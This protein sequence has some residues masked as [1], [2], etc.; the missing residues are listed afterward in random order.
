LPPPNSQLRIV[1]DSVDVSAS[2][3]QVWAAIGIFGDMRWHP[4]IAQARVTGTGMGQ[5]RTIETIDGKQIIER[6]ESIDNSQRTYRYAMIS[7]MPAADYGATLGVKPKSGGSSVEWRV[8]YLADG[9]PDI[10]VQAI[11]SALLKI[12]LNS[13]KTRFGPL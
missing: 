13:L 10:V 9:Q 4:L 3:D 5:L 11:V 6:L 12:G 1:V 8:Q 7:G 2:P